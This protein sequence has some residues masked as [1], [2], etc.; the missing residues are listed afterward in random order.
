MCKIENSFINQFNWEWVEAFPSFFWKDF[1]GQFFVR[2]GALNAFIS[3]K[4]IGKIYDRWR[5]FLRDN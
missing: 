4:I 5:C 3:S 2:I 1:H